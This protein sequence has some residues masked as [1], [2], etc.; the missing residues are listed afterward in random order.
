MSAAAAASSGDVI[1]LRTLSIEPSAPAPIE[2]PLKLNFA[3]DAS[4]EL[5]EAFWDFKVKREGAGEAE[6]QEELTL[7]WRAKTVRCCCRG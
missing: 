3:F 4:R 1:T 7:T 6:E 5:P 2:A